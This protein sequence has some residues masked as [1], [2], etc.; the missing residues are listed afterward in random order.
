MTEQGKPLIE[1]KT[2]ILHRIPSMPEHV[3]VHS[4][5]DITAGDGARHDV[6]EGKGRWANTT[7]SNVFRFLKTCGLPVAWESQVDEKSFL[8]KR[9]EMVPL[10]VVARRKAYGS[11]LQRHPGFA[12]G[13]VFPVPFLE[14]FLKTTGKR[15]GEHVYPQDDPLLRPSTSTDGTRV[16]VCD[17]HSPR[18]TKFG[19]LATSELGPGWHE[20]YRIFLLA[21]RAFKFLEEQWAHLGCSLCDMKLE[22]GL[23]GD[24]LLIADVIDNDSWRLFEGERQLDKQVYR[25]GADLAYVAECYKRVA[26]LSDRFAATR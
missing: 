2:K 13:A 26:E 16:F 24:E 19:D 23:W 18:E 22:F 1:G 4:K 15:F 9:C 5:D 14:M 3:L 12:K 6:I 25:D 10:E 21:L 7:T 11:Y 20:R 17:A 8:A